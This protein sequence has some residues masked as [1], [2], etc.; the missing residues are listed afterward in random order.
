MDLSL[1]SGRVLYGTGAL[2]GIAALLY[3]GAEIILGL[4][5]TVKAAMLLLGFAALFTGGTATRMPLDL[6]LYVLSAAAYLSFLV[7][8]LGRFSLATDHVFLA[9]GLS[10]ALFI[11]LGHAVRE[12][13]LPDVAPRRVLIGIGIVAAVLLAGDVAGPDATV[14]TT[15]VDT[16]TLED[17]GEPVIGTVTVT[18]RFVLSRDV[19]PPALDACVYTA[20]MERR[21]IRVS[22]DGLSGL[23]GGGETVT[24]NLTATV[25]IRNDDG[26]V[27]GERTYAVER[28]D[29]CPGA[30][31]GDRIVVVDGP[32]FD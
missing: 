31:D 3:F 15:F 25:V 28:R 32:R 2:L 20:G 11:G 5:P 10:S 19:E 4:S 16:V 7:Y 8:T 29:D 13:L 23:V 24:A 27:T 26:N 14:E 17:G 1:D 6:T 9:L 18:N 22:A 21:R 30:V 12:E